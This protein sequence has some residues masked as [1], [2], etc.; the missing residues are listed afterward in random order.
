MNCFLWQHAVSNHNVRAF[1]FISLSI[2][3]CNPSLPLKAVP[4]TGSSVLPPQWGILLQVHTQWQGGKHM[5]GV[6]WSSLV[7]RSKTS[8]HLIILCVW[9]CRGGIRKCVPGLRSHFS[10]T[11]THTNRYSGCCRM[12]FSLHALISVG[13]RQLQLCLLWVCS[14]SRHTVEKLYE[15]YKKNMSGQI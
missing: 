15:H 13:W 1:Q 8:A 12:L 7:T 2:L 10:L 3:L 11:R 5:E 9:S 6:H 14:V 4:I